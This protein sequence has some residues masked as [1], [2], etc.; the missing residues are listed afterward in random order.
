MEAD[1]SR[2]IPLKRD[3]TVPIVE[4]EEMEADT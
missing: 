3:E 4:D 2:P 1:L